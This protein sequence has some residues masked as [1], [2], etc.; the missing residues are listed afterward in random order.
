LPRILLFLA[1]LTVFLVPTI[2]S[3]VRQVHADS[4]PDL[5]VDTIWLEDASNPGQPVTQVAPD[6]PFLIVASI[7]NLGSAAA[8]G[9]YLDVYYDSSYGRGGPD[10][11]APGETQTW[12]V[13]PVT[14]QASTHT[15]KWVVNPDKQIAESNYDNN[16]KDF[17]F[18]VG[19]QTQ[20][21]TTSQTTQVVTSTGTMNVTRYTTKT[22]TSYT[23]TQTSTST[24]VV[25]TTVTV[26]PSSTT[27]TL[28]T[29]QRLTVRSTAQVTSYTT[30]TITSYTATTTSTSTVTVY[31]TVANSAA[32]A[33][34]AS[35]SL[36][37]LGFLSLLSLAV[38]RVMPL[39]GVVHPGS[40]LWTKRRCS[41]D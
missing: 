29:T 14:G 12:Y 25:L 9:F 4:L 35:S 30:M 13:G 39:R 24:I 21:T 31:K 34:G 40:R 1:V 19:Q 36:T 8:T 17:T 41:S 3:P 7:K 18:T 11:I 6:D 33:G 22:V 32:E 26:S 10:S 5:T 28:Q 20:P 16:E 38:G 23:D 2:T 37:F 27:S 15:T